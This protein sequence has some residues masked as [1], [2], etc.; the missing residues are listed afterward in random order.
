MHMNT[1]TLLET[2]VETEKALQRTDYLEARALVMRA[3]EY[4]LQLER[5]MIHV[6]AEKLRRAA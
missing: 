6:Q 5:E 3:E 4:V 2:L 1:A